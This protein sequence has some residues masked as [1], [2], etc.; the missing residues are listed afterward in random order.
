MHAAEGGEGPPLREIDQFKK[1]I[2][3]N[4]SSIDGSGTQ[5]HD[6]DDYFD[7]SKLI[8][9]LLDPF[10]IL[11]IMCRLKIP[12]FNKFG[13]KMEIF[14]RRL[15]TMRLNTFNVFGIAHRL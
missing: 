7:G 12:N 1:I 6:F 2:R 10:I 11:S 15:T 4:Y 14:V 3:E 5:I 8:H 13:L 9:I